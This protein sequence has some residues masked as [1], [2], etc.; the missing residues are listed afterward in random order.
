MTHHRRVAL[1]LHTESGCRPGL[2]K[3]IRFLAVSNGIVITCQTTLSKVTCSDKQTPHPLQ[4]QARRRCGRPPLHSVHHIVDA[5]WR[6][7]GA[8]L[9]RGGGTE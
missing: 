6:A 8:A 3:A 7:A 5:V 2:W 1:A 9:M 4:H